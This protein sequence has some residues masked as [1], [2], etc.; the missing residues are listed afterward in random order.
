MARA[1]DKSISLTRKCHP[2]PFGQHQCRADGAAGKPRERGALV[3]IELRQFLF[4]RVFHFAFGE[5]AQIE[6]LAARADGGNQPSRI[7]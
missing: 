5:R 4:Q 3:F 7:V 1:F 6:P 2:L